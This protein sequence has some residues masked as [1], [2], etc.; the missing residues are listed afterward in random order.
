MLAVAAAQ[1][2]AQ[3]KGR[4]NTNPFGQHT[5]YKGSASQNRPLWTPF[6][7]NLSTQTFF[8]NIFL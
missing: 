5:G 2:R 4:K 1:K 6:P 3:R 8:L 7:A